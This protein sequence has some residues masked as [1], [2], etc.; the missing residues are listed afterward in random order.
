MFIPVNQSDPNIIHDYL[1]PQ[2]N[3]SGNP[4]RP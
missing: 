3:Y 2:S 4:V 1:K